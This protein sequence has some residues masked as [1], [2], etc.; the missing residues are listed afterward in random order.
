VNELER[1]VTLESQQLD[2][3]GAEFQL[4][5]L[6]ISQPGEPLSREELIPRVF[7]RESTGLDRSIDN[8]VNNLMRLRIEPSRS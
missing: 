2:L 4:L 7:G 5:K 1:S 6:L 8:L 3:T